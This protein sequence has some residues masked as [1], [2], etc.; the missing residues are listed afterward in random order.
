MR[1]WYGA[2]AESQVERVFVVKLPMRIFVHDL[3]RVGQ[4]LDHQASLATPAEPVGK[5]LDPGPQAFRTVP[6]VHTPCGQFL[7]RA[8]VLPL[9][10][11]D[12]I[13][14]PMNEPW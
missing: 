7:F 9:L 12:A 14:R 10:P 5:N 8:V 6:R 3:I 13:L 11:G 4:A 2:G 1:G